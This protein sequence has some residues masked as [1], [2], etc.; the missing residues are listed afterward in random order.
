MPA[1]TKLSLEM[2]FSTRAI[3][4]YTP[5]FSYMGRGGWLPF[6]TFADFIDVFDLTI[7][8]PKEYEILG[9]GRRVKEW[10]EGDVKI[11]EWKADSPVSFPSITFGRYESDRPGFDAKKPDGTVIPIAVHVDKASFQDWGIRPKAL[12]PLANQAANAINLYTEISGL[13]YPYGELNI[14]NDYLGGL[15]GQAPSSLIYLGSPVFRG[16]GFLAQFFTSPTRIS[17]FLKSVTAHEVGHQWWGAR[18]SNANSRNYW[19]V[20]SLAE[21]FSAIFLEAVHGWKEYE[22]QVAEWR[23]D[24]LNTRIKTSVQNASSLYGGEDGGYQALV[25][26]KGPYAFHILR[27]TFKGEGPRGPEGADRKFFEALKKFSQ[28]LAERREIVTL[29]MQHALEKAFGGVDENGQPYNA[30]L[31]W[32]F[33][34]WIRGTGVPQF[35]FVYDVRRTEDGAYLIEGT[36]RERVII[37]S[38]REMD[39]VIEGRYYRGVVDITARTSGGKEYRTRRVIDAAE[40]PFRL[41]VPEKPVEVV[42]NQDGAMLTHDPLVNRSF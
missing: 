12:R 4:K 28:E 23:A 25:Y 37:G 35:S 32:F 42:L 10:T 30:K 24:I 26:A 14:V 34:Q 2:N 8:L 39:N 1:G 31:D 7:K 5:S 11:S 9:V 13:E 22:E 20:E 17:K 15:Y 41:K 36:I 27:E 21:Y 40:T 3:I 19:F 18:V 6:V 33:D 16:E 29:D 38:K